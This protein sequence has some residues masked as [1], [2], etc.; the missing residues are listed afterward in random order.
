MSAL[1]GCTAKP[2]WKLYEKGGLVGA[3]KPLLKPLLSPGS[4]PQ[5]LKLRNP[6]KA[7][8]FRSLFYFPFRISYSCSLNYAPKSAYPHIT[9][10]GGS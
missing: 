4:P 8:S 5:S 9:G 10:K 6:E 3:L 1:L 2:T 7:E